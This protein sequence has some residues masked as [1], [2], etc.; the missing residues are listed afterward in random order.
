[1]L[2]NITEKE[3]KDFH[4]V[5]TERV[6][7]LPANIKTFRYKCIHTQPVSDIK[8][9]SKIYIYPNCNIK[10]L[11]L[12]KY[13]KAI[14]CKQVFKPEEANVLVVSDDIRKP[15]YLSERYKIPAGT[16]MKAND[17]KSRYVDY[18]QDQYASQFSLW[19]FIYNTILGGSYSSYYAGANNHN[20]MLA[21][22]SKFEKVYVYECPSKYTEH[23]LLS[24]IKPG[25]M[26]IN[27]TDLQQVVYDWEVK[28][29]VREDSSEYNWSGIQD[30]LL[31]NDETNGMLALK[32][33]EKIDIAPILNKLVACY[34]SRNMHNATALYLKDKVFVRNPDLYEIIPN[35]Y[36]RVYDHMFSQFME[37]QKHTVFKF[38][39]ADLSLIGKKAVKT[40]DGRYTLAD[41]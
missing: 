27:E 33:I 30:L 10:K 22:L 31:S 37:L 32:I 16:Y 40:D 21:E 15:L 23:H 39:V 2:L 17:Q 38:D 34:F 18:I 25:N 4:N 20:L 5:R 8:E 11:P 13:I 29:K 41:L 19:Y 7:D 24:L 26:L 12:R 28:E 1:M 6:K 9:E 3:F 14:K 36:Y 35:Y